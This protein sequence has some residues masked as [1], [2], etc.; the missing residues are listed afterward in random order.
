MVL[1]IVHVGQ[2]DSNAIVAELNESCSLC[3][4]GSGH[5]ALGCLELPER[6]QAGRRGLQRPV[7]EVPRNGC[8]SRRDGGGFRGAGRWM[9]S[10]DLFRWRAALHGDAGREPYGVHSGRAHARGGPV[11]EP[12]LVRR[13][14][15]VVGP[16]VEMEQGVAVDD[17]GGLR[18]ELD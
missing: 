13:E 11:E 7:G 4:P 18:L 17:I 8:D 2:P 1:P 6:R 14:E 9:A 15:H 5:L 10:D 3:E 12:D 16:H